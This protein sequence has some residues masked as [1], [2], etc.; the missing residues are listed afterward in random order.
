MI[1][2]KVLQGFVY[3]TNQIQLS[4]VLNCTY[5]QTTHKTCSK[6][7]SSTQFKNLPSMPHAGS[8]L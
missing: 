3:K 2:Q 4:T 5:T 1:K 7:N 6:D 8:S